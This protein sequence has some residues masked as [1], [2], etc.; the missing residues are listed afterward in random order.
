LKP[1]HPRWSGATSLHNNTLPELPQLRSLGY[2]FHLNPVLAP[3]TELRI[4]QSL[5][6]ASIVSE[7]QQPLTVGIQSTCGINLG[8][9]DEIGQTGPAT[10]SFRRELTQYPEGFV[11]QDCL[12]L[13]S[14]I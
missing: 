11:K 4:R 12:V 7:Q 6:N 5:L 8:N 1:A 14:A 3:V 9:I 13:H 10:S 2:P